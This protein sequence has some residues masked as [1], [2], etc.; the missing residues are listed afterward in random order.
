MFRDED[1][2]E[3]EA[4]SQEYE[5]E[6]EPLTL[7]LILTLV[8]VLRTPTLTRS[9]IIS[10]KRA[11]N[12]TLIPIRVQKESVHLRPGSIGINVAFTLLDEMMIYLSTFTL[13]GNL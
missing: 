12:A 3:T 11:V 6:L 9:P 4:G 8:L 13:H 5:L 2:S 10:S 1:V 7:I